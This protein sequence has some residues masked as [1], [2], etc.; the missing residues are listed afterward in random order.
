[1]PRY[2]STFMLLLFGSS[3]AL[4]RELAGLKSALSKHKL[5]ANHPAY[6]ALLTL[7]EAARLSVAHR[8]PVSIWE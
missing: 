2:L 6:V 1:M 5:P 4:V 3:V 8:V 7:E